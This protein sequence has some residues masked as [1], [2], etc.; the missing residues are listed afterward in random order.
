[1]A[2]TT[3]ASTEAPEPTQGGTTGP[4]IAPEAPEQGK[5]G[6]E[7]AKYRTQLRET[8]AERDTLRETVSALRREQAEA[9][10]DKTLARPES[11][12]LTGATVDEY[13]DEAGKLDRSRLIADAQSAISKQGIAAFRRFAAA[14]DQGARSGETSGGKTWQD[15]LGG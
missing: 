13:I 1:M 12:W 15:V 8:E 9:A 10:L 5:A 14:A 6:R 2:D 3:D 4:E 11:F 7:A